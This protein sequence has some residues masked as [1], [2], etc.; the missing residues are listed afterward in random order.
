MGCDWVLN[1]KLIEDVCGI[2]GGN[3]VNCNVTKG[4]FDAPG[5]PGKQPTDYIKQHHC[6][7]KC[8]II[9]L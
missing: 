4:T 5:T 8:N 2:C 7:R 9:I 6:F 3:G 1:S